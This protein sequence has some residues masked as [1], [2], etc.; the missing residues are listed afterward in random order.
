M[1]YQNNRFSFELANREDGEQIL[2]ILEE[3]DFKGKVALIY[4]RRPDAYSSLKREGEEVVII[5]CRDHKLDRGAGFAAC[6][7]NRLYFNGEEK[8]VGYLSGLR[9]ARKYRKQFHLLHRGYHFL[10]DI[11]ADKNIDYYLTT[12]LEENKIVQRLLEK[13][14]KFM[15]W[16]EYLD[17]YHVYT[18]KTGLRLNEKKRPEL[19]L[20]QARPED[21]SQ[22]LDFIEKEGGSNQFFP[23]LDK[24][25]LKDKWE[26]ESGDFYYLY[27]QDSN[28]IV[29]AGAC[30]DQTEYKQYIVQNYGGI[31]K[32]LAPIS[33]VFPLFGY[34]PLPPVGSIL[35]FFTLSFWTVKDNDGDIF[36]YFLSSISR[37]FGGIYSFFNIGL[38]SSHPLCGIVKDIPHLVYKSR[39][40]LVNWEKEEERVG[41]LKDKYPLYLECGLL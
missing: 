2:D 21:Y 8:R 14:R 30:W 17:Q 6:S 26:L 28:Q 20:K 3:N 15:P 39:L 24:N 29:A 32:L 16:Y 23:I 33:K 9:I 34:P 25:I 18:I 31:Y 22:V 27:D 37:R 36:Q 38:I 10:E 19:I 40:Y 35:N 1:N 13:K 12:I 11:L 41:Q 7:I 5:V 4:T